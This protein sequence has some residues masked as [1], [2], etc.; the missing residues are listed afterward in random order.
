MQ[1]PSPRFRSKIYF[2]YEISGE[3]FSPDLYVFSC[4][5]K[6]IIKVKSQSDRQFCDLNFSDVMGKPAITTSM[7][8]FIKKEKD[9][10]QF[11]PL[12]MCLGDAWF[13]LCVD[14]IRRS[15]LVC[16]PQ[17]A[18]EQPFLRFN[19][20]NEPKIRL[21]EPILYQGYLFHQ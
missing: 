10:P 7:S 2:V 12:A 21:K 5:I 17:S 15:D 13:L 19:P 14:Q 18:T 4:S 3:M 6:Y 1:R 16:S 11:E 20:A 8:P 9:F